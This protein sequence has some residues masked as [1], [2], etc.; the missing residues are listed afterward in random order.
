MEGTSYGSKLGELIKEKGITQR[1]LAKKS[2][3]DESTISLYI[4]GRRTPNIKNHVRLCKALQ[5][6]S[7]FFT[8]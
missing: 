4:S 2:E 5:V 6:E 8:L 3:L 7:N 1:E